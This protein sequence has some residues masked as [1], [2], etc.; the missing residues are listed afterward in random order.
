MSL[1]RR[2]FLKTSAFSAAALGLSQFPAPSIALAADAN[3]KLRVGVVGI[4]GRGAGKNIRTPSGSSI[5]VLCSTKWTTSTP[6]S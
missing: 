1:N 5:S 3:S 2:Q 4:S 6:F